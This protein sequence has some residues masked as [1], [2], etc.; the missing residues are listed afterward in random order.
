MAMARNAKV[1]HHSDDKGRIRFFYGEV[2]GNNQ[3]LQQTMRD[4]ASAMNRPLPS[5][6]P[7]RASPIAELA[8]P[9]EPDLY[10]E[11]PEREVD[12]PEQ[13]SEQQAAVESPTNGSARRRRGEGQKADHNAGLSPVGDLDLV[14][15]EKTS[16]REFVEEKV[17]NTDEE[18]VLVFVYY[19]KEKCKVAKVTANH[20]LTCFRHLPHRVPADLRSTIRNLARKK[21]LLNA[22]DPED[23]SITTSGIGVVEHD[24]PR[25]NNGKQSP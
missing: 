5:T 22:S 19:M 13:M 11:V 21:A 14:Q 16:L 10:S 8:R 24:L 9:S 2:E 7:R 12:V 6:L 23:I 15:K 17:P 3:T 18:Y 25:S 4:F 1:D 20:V